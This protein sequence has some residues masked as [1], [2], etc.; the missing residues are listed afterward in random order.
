VRLVDAHRPFSRTRLVFAVLSG[1]VG[2]SRVYDQRAVRS[3]HIRSLDGPLRLASDGE[4]FDGPDDIHV[5]KADRRL[6]VVTPRE[7]S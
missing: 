2:R 3:M 1:R 6:V 5:A 4:T 7:P